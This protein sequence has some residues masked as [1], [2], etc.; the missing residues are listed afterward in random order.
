MMGTYIRRR[1]VSLV[2]VVFLAS[3][4]VFSLIRLL[5]GDPAQAIAG[6]TATPEQIEAIRT[7]LGLDRSIVV[8][9]GLWIGRAIRGDFGQ[10]FVNGITVS[11]L[12]GQ[13]LPA[14][15]QL[16]VAGLILALVFG[17]ATGVAAGLRSNGVVDRIV[18]A[19]NVVALGV[20]SFSLGLILLIVFGLKLH[21]M[22][23]SGYE[24]LLEDPGS[25]LRHLTLPAVTLG[26]LLMPP[27][28]L[29]VRDGILAQLDQDHVRTATAMG[30]PR[31]T[32]IRA[33]LLR[34]AFIPVLTMLGLITGN[35]LSGAVV[36]EVVFSW[37]GL[38]SLALG[39]VLGSDF[40]TVQAIVLLAVMAFVLVNLLT[41]LLHAKLDPR[42]L[43]DGV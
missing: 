9:Y 18:S 34:N 15:L 29:L 1:L 33:N 24:S 35:L 40:P 32:I 28:S 25:A 7:N 6:D 16:A 10:S 37:P 3:V 17:V 20:P 23:L 22:P 41:D 2:V 14:T 27:I 43:K 38:G 30:L 36:V 19:L 31:A 5:P 39:A 42:V 8:Q 4:I 21:W 26:F 11:E 13:R 12:I